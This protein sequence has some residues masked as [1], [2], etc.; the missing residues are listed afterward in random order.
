MRILKINKYHLF[1]SLNITNVL[2]V[3][4]KLK[5]RKYKYKEYITIIVDVLFL[6]NLNNICQNSMFTAI[7]LSLT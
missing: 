1:S 5:P 4:L 2:E 3:F 6:L 7:D